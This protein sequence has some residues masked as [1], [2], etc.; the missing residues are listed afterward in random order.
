MP[1]I[2]TAFDFLF[3]PITR[4]LPL[5]LIYQLMHVRAPVCI[6]ISHRC[7]TRVY[8][9]GGQR[10]SSLFEDD[11]VIRK[12]SVPVQSKCEDCVCELLKKILNDSLEV[13][14]HQ[15]LLIINKNTSH[16]VSVDGMDPTIFTL[17]SLDSETCCAVFCFKSELIDSTSGTTPISGTLVEDCRNI[18]GVILIDDHD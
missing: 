16:P 6:N 18:A 9:K 14:N 11:Y 12:Q 15:K 3:N 13:F 4:A 5:L 1:K 8:F 2:Q 10:M 7:V 17:E